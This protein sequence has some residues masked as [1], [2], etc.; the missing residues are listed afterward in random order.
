[1]NLLKFSVQHIWGLTQLLDRVGI[2]YLI[3]VVL[4]RHDYDNLSFVKGS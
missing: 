2:Q 1:L 4:L 3:T